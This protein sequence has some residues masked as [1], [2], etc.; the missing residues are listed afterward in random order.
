MTAIILRIISAPAGETPP[1]PFR[2]ESGR[3]TIG[4]RDGNAWVLPDASGSVSRE[5]AVIEAVHGSWQIV[6]HSA[7]GTFVNGHNVGNGNA[8]PLNAGDSLRIGDY[9][10]VVE[11]DLEEAQPGDF[12]GDD[13]FADAFHERAYG[14]PPPL[15]HFP[16]A[17]SE[18]PARETLPSDWNTPPPAELDPIETALAELAPQLP[19]TADVR[20][21]DDTMA[22]VFAPDRIAIGDTAMVQVFLHLTEQATEAEDLARDFD[23]DAARRGQRTLASSIPEGS[24]VQVTLSLPGL[25]V[26]PPI[27][28][29]VWRRRAESAQFAVT[30]PTDRMAGGV[31]G[32][33]R[34]LIEGAPIGELRFKMTVTAGSALGASHGRADTRGRL[35]RRAFTSYASK[36]RAEVLRR[37][38]VL[39][40]V[41]IEVFQDVLDLEP[42]QRWERELYRRIDEC[43]VV[44]LFWSSAARESQWVEREIDYALT[45]QQREPTAED[46]PDMPAIEPLPIEGPPIPEPWPRLKHLH[47][48]DALLYCID[49]E[50]RARGR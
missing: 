15:S 11:A 4:R 14:A 46:A 16:M 43:D 32:T 40:R 17:R 29:I 39:R 42:G 34:I 35:Y 50:D 37:V 19:V 6:D 24:S 49:G 22:S 21:D 20:R 44:L 8:W 48:N 30:V 28:T 27:D 12:I 33:V 41:G 10:I 25:S 18:S 7:N 26:D 5:H 9:E 23:P 3:A 1:P 31:V 36:D 13:R 2:L 45:R 38:Q 47:F